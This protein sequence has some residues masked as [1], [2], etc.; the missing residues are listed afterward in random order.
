MRQRRD[1]DAPRRRRTRCPLGGNQETQNTGVPPPPPAALRD[2][3]TTS[4]SAI[5]SRRLLC[6]CCVVFFFFCSPLCVFLASMLCCV[7]QHRRRHRRRRQR[8]QRHYIAYNITSTPGVRAYVRTRTTYNERHIWNAQC[9]KDD[10]LL[11]QCSESVGGDG[12]SQTARRRRG[13]RTIHMNT[14]H[15]HCD[16]AKGAENQHKLCMFTRAYPC[17]T[18]YAPST[19]MLHSAVCRIC[20]GAHAR[21]RVFT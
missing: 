6:K 11:R 19:Y 8:R 13:V 15:R 21:E 10:A 3:P 18:R 4:K 5:Y 16:A 9:T 7:V 20:A 12:A 14:A 17:A 2:K 1:N